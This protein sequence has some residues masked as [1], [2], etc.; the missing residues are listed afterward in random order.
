MTYFEQKNLLVLCVP[1]T[2]RESE[3]YSTLTL[4][5]SSCSV[6]HAI[7]HPT[8]QLI[9]LSYCQPDHTSSPFNSINPLSQELN[10]C[11]DWGRSNILIKRPY[12]YSCSNDHFP[13]KNISVSSGPEIS[14]QLCPSIPE[15]TRLLSSFPRDVITSSLRG[16]PSMGEVFKQVERVASWLRRDGVQSGSHETSSILLD[17]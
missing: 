6:I 3:I 10:N 13:W 4:T 12:I 11:N 2:S 8:V 15:D 14:H 5:L 17:F 7:A 1:P 16:D 9:P